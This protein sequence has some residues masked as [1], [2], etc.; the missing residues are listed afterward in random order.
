MHM[1]HARTF[2]GCELH[3]GAMFEVYFI[4]WLLFQSIRG[5]LCL[6]RQ[7]IPGVRTRSVSCPAGVTCQ[8][9]SR[10]LESI[11]ATLRAYGIL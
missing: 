8:D 9:R 11:V 5:L 4:S 10:Q 7:C 1:L 3:V 6:L 2:W